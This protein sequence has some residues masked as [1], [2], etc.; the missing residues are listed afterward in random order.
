MNLNSNVNPCADI[1]RDPIIFSTVGPRVVPDTEPSNW[2]LRICINGI[3][4]NVVN[5]NILDSFSETNIYP[6]TITN[7]I[8]SFVTTTSSDPS[9]NSSVV[10]RL[11]PRFVQQFVSDTEPSNISYST[12]VPVWV[13]TVTVLP[14]ISNV[15]SNFVS[16]V[17]PGSYSSIDTTNN[18]SLDS[19][20][21]LSFDANY[22]Q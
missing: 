13:N 21:T 10:S 5:T 4:M 6:S 16:S 2:S 11:I 17:L 20:E 9:F 8:S 12:Q 14:S 19:R 18:P 3:R 15:E 7:N 1:Q 22:H